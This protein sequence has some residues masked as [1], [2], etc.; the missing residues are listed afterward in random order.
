MSKVL[1]ERPRGGWRTSIATRRYELRRDP[2]N[3]P[4]DSR[5]P[6]GRNGTKHFSDLLGPLKR[7]VRRQVGRPWDKVYSE[8]CEHLRPTS[9]L[10]QHVFEHLWHYVER[11]VEEREGKV[12]TLDGW[13][14]P[15]ELRE[16][17][18]YVCPR[19]GLLREYRPRQRATEL[20]E[21]GRHWVSDHILHTWID[22]AWHAVYFAPIPSREREPEAFD[23]ILGRYLHRSGAALVK[24]ELVRVHKREGVY[25]YRRRKLTRSERIVAG[26][27]RA[28]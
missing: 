10:Q 20:R 23:V 14:G 28:L 24:T 19:T 11:R 25:A 2:D 16:G 27:P 15:Y 3:V 9:T 7:Y 17:R 26:L 1:I 6:V 8:I 22:G 13:T 5:E 4:L 21:I 18:F 12:F